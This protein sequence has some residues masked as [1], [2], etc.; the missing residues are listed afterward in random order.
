MENTE[1]RELTD[2]ISEKRVKA[3]SFILSKLAN[4]TKKKKKSKWPAIVCGVLLFSALLTVTRNCYKNS[5]ESSALFLELGSHIPGSDWKRYEIASA[6]S[7]YIPSSMELRHDYDDYTKLLKNKHVEIGKADAVFQQAELANLS[8]EAFDT[9]CRV[10]VQHYNLSPGE[11]E[12]HNQA[13]YITPEDKNSFREVVDAELEPYSYV[14]IPTFQWVDIAGTKALE[15]RYRRSGSKGPVVCRL[16]LLP[17]YDE[18]VKMIISY[19]E[20]DGDIW[21]SDLENII[22]TFKWNSP[23]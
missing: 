20:S 2:A 16:Y 21:K 7:I 22:K 19:R 15:A 5:L 18:L 9:Y 11:V 6:F 12:H 23:K 4:S 13:S 8:T 3:K 17:N 14:D 1:N 10:I